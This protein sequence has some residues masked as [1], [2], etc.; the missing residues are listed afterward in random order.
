MCPLGRKLARSNPNEWSRCG[1][2]ASLT[3]VLR[4]GTCLASRALTRNTVKPRA[5]RS[6][7]IGIQYTLVDSITTVSTPHSLN[8]FTSRCRSV[9]KVPKLRTGSGVQS[10][11]TAAMCIVAP[12]SMAA[13]FGWTIGIVRSTLDLVLFRSE[14]NTPE[15]QTRQYLLCH[16]LL[17]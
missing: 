8:Q 9:V 10:A 2:C 17:Y 7:K 4:P 5:S 3:S 15:L 12:T 16:L 13:A 14:D 1:H 11:L 6:S